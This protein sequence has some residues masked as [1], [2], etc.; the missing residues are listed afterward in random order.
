MAHREDHGDG[1]RGLAEEGGRST[2]VVVA[3][4]AVGRLMQG[5][6]DMQRSNQVGLQRSEALEHWLVWFD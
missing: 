4:V 1:L 5:C 2:T 6:N 3:V